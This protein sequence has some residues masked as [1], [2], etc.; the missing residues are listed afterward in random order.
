MKHRIQP[1][2]RYTLA[3][4]VLSLLF[5]RPRHFISP[6]TMAGTAVVML[7]VN[8]NKVLLGQRG[9]VVESAGRWSGLGG[10][11]E[12]DRD[13]TFAQALCREL[14]EE[15]HLRL[16]PARLAPSPDMA[17]FAHHQA[18]HEISDMHTMCAYYVFSVPA[19]F[20]QKLQITDEAR[21]YRWFTEAEV[22]AMIADGRIPPEFEDL[23]QAARE[24]FR[25][26][27]KG[28]KFPPLP[29]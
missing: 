29:I 25:R 14:E 24:L 7:V 22:E 11:V 17:F 27:N 16:N 21:D 9:G 1:G 28:E 2:W 8:G 18:K 4:K 3:Q 13:E 12:L 15:T 20:T 5:G 23:H 10:F 6:W 26:L 19:T